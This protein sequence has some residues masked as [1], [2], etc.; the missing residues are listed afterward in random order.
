MSAAT[1]F[2][3]QTSHLAQQEL[4]LHLVHNNRKQEGPL[5]RVAFQQLSTQRVK[6]DQT[7]AAT[8]SSAQN[9]KVN[10]AATSSGRMRLHLLLDLHASAVWPATF[11]Q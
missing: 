5:A 11:A 3:G 9:H 4:A 1:S 6:K 2:N 8:S 7:V 10:S